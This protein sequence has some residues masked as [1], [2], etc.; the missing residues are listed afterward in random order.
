MQN[1][2]ANIYGAGS[3]SQAIAHVLVKNINQI[4]VIYRN[5]NNF[6][7]SGENKKINFSNDLLSSI[8]SNNDPLIVC[9]PVSSLKDLGENL[10]KIKFSR[11]VLLCCKGIE[12]NTGKFPSEI[13]EEFISLDQIAILTGPSFSDEV[14]NDKPT[15][16]I[17]SGQKAEVIELFTTMFHSI[18]FRVYNSNDVI[19]CQLG[20]ALK[21]ILSIA[22]GIAEGLKLGANAKA[23]L[24][25]RGILEMKYLGDKVQCDPLTIFGL[26]GLGDLVLTANDDLSRNRSFG[27]KIGEGLPI[28]DSANSIG[29]TIE[30]INASKGLSV[31]TRKYSLDLPICNKVFE[32]IQ[33]KISPVEGVSQLL[34]RDQRNEID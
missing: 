22:V 5:D 31:L 30:G 7:K 6:V 33:K 29:K 10:K 2:H 18:N 3:W 16:V 27:I 19:G 8:N 11:P 15:A 17:I 25:S 12:S 23:A 34:N 9:S 1:L 14:L 32:I 20:G 28:E 24:I 21:N 26:S 13:L 4:T